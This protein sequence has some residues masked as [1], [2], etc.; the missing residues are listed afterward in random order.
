V[1]RRARD[2]PY[3]RWRAG[4]LVLWIVVGLTVVIVAVRWLVLAARSAGLLP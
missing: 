3:A 4:V 1:S 2:E